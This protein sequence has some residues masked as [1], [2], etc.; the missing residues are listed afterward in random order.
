M[1]RFQEALKLLLAG[2]ELDRRAA[3]AAMDSLIGGEATD[4]QAG[5]FL[6]ALRVRG[7]TIEELVGF[8]QAMRA[9]AVKVTPK[10]KPLLD[11][12]GTGGDGS[13]TFNISTATAFVAAGA[14][15]AV[16]KHGNRAVAGLVFIPRRI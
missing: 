8:A 10:R 3:R 5:A 1:A 11:T 14:G 4:A 2:K 6:A 13:G 9:K 15:A 16:A 7:E 12:C